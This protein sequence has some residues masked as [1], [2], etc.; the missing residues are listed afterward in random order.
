MSVMP[1]T[2]TARVFQTASVSINDHFAQ[3]FLTAME[4]FIGQPPAVFEMCMI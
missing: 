4:L 3:Q 2:K 1:I